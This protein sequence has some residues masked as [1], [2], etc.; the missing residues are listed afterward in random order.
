MVDKTLY[1]DDIAN[2]KVN[3]LDIYYDVIANGLV[4]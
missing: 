2:R 1:V 4:Y 3:Y